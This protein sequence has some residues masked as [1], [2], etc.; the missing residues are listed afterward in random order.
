MLEALFGCPLEAWDGLYPDP[1]YEVL[2]VVADP[3]SALGRSWLS[4]S[5][6]ATH[7]RKCAQ[8][9]H[10][11][12]VSLRH[13]GMPKQYGSCPVICVCDVPD[14]DATLPV[15]PAAVCVAGVARVGADAAHA[16]EAPRSISFTQEATNGHRRHIARVSRYSVS[17]PQHDGAPGGDP[18]SST[19]SGSG[20]PRYAGTL[21][22]QAPSTGFEGI[23]L[24]MRSGL[25]ARILVCLL[26]RAP[27]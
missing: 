3:G 7:L 23:L 27:V 10:V 24:P 15:F 1:P 26:A 11:M 14:P 8:D 17:S 19:G 18:S 13:S 4:E 20:P 25:M 9:R 12:D 22:S 21:S 5:T 2:Y 6:A 16:D